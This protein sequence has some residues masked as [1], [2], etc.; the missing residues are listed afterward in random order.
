M[1]LKDSDKNTTILKKSGDC[2]IYCSNTGTTNPG[3]TRK[4]DNPLRGIRNPI[5][6]KLDNPLKG[7]RSLVLNRI[8]NQCPRGLTVQT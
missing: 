8:W 1:F 7:I 4:Q 3:V 6:R 5:I 2:K